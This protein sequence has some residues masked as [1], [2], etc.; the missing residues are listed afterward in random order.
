MFNTTPF[1][2]PKIICAFSQRVDGNMKLGGGPAIDENRKK[3]FTKIGIDS[4]NTV[5]AE[6]IHKNV[7]TIVG[8]D[9]CGE[10]IQGTDGLV[11][12]VPG[13]YLSITAADCLPIYAY[14]PD[15]NIVG[16]IHVGWRGLGLGAVSAFFDAVGGNFEAKIGGFYVEIGPSI[17]A[18]HY[19]VDSDV[20]NRFSAYQN[21]IISKD[22]K[23]YL[24]LKKVAMQQC[25]EAGILEKNII[26]PDIC[27]YE[28]DNY[29]SHRRERQSPVL[30]GMAI[31]G[32]KE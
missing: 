7:T 2:S 26:L 3:F 15:A 23:T 18:N 4:K 22:K 6:I 24:D 27:T 11:T 31:I 5:S 13:I 14:N 29:F 16:L 1:N 8:S 12:S 19:E 17:C 32:M 25:L 21:A 28:D 20:V 30:A 9:N 10:I